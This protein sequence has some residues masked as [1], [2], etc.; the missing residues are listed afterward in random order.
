VALS[1]TPQQRVLRAR[2]AAHALHAQG[3]T[4]TGPATAASLARFERQVDPDGVLDPVERARRAAHAR[5][6]YMTTLALKASRARARRRDD[7]PPAA[8]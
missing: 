4:N 8:A 2:A 1:L 3:G 7:E 5:K 6:S